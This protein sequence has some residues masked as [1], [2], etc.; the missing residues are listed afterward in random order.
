MPQKITLTLTP[1]QL[2]AFLDEFVCSSTREQTE[3]EL[4]TF[5][6]FEKPQKSN[7]KKT[8]NKMSVKELAE[9]ASEYDKKGVVA[10][11]HKISVVSDYDQNRYYDY[12]YRNEIRDKILNSPI[13]PK[14]KVGDLIV[15]KNIKKGE[16]TVYTDGV[17]IVGHDLKIVDLPGE[18]DFEYGNLP[19]E[20]RIWK[21]RNPRTGKLVNIDYWHGAE[22]FYSLTF[23]FD[24]KEL[25]LHFEKSDLQLLKLFDYEKNDSLCVSFDVGDGNTY[26]IVNTSDLS[27]RKFLKKVNRRGWM[28]D[29][30]EQDD[31]TRK[32]TKV[33]GMQ[34]DIRPAL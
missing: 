6:R 15:E 4:L 32:N 12:D 8:G 30:D 19:R 14:A 16:L 22:C 1:D 21:F 23:Y 33:F 11:I 7:L 27:E 29:L 3:K 31:D 10:K 5:K 28:Y 26:Y 17:Y 24:P 34:D 20:F 25:N 13:P 2:A 9:K 18:P